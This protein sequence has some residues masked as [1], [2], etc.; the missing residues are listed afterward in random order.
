MSK[1]GSAGA[2]G[3]LMHIIEVEAIFCAEGTNDNGSGD[4]STL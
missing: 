2:I 3:I 1:T 4:P